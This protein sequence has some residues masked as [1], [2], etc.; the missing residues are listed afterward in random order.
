MDLSR[1]SWR[2][3]AMAWML[4]ASAHAQVSGWLDFNGLVPG[5][6]KATGHVDWI[7]IQ[8]FQIAGARGFGQ[9]GAFGMSKLLDRASPKLFLACARGTVFP[10]ATLDLN[11]TTSIP[12]PPGPVRILL[13]DVI[14][15]SY[16]IGSG[17]D[18]P[19][20]AF[21]LAFGKITYTY[22]LNTADSVISSYDY[23]SNTGSSGSGSATDSDGDG[24]PDEWE[25]AHDLLV[26]Y[27]DAD[28]DADGDG[29]TNLQEYLLGTDPRSGASFFK[30]TVAPVSGSPGIYQLT[31]NS[32]V[33]KDYVI[34]WSPDLIIPFATLRTV[35]A[36]AT[37]TRENVANAGN[38]GFY[39]VRL[40]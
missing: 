26:G 19:H 4:A 33:G 6:S 16:G 8:G 35:T 12:S 29:F 24:M 38:I 34:E 18:R 31:W 39:R 3:S 21:H 15:F 2:C 32:V 17:G 40:R 9:P 20:E 30:V 22:Y 7:E 23:R 37:T 27:N 5:E 14:I 10:K 36:T 25:I 13:E 28:E 1:S 11:Y